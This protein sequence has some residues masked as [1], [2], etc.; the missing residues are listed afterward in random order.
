MPALIKDGPVWTLDLGGDENRFSPDF[1]TEVDTALDEI[2]ASAEPAVLLTTGSG[3]FFSNGLD[4]DWIMAHAGELPGYVDRIHAM[5]AKVLTL[6]V[7][8]VAAIN[9][10]AFG[11]GAMLAI[12]HDFRVMRDDRGFFCF[13]EVDILIPFTAGMNALIVAKT[14]PQAQVASMTTGRRW[15][16][17][18][19]AEAGLVDEATSLDRLREAAEAR[20][21]PLAGKDRRTLGRIKQVLYAGAVE[22]LLEPQPSDLTF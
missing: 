20:V 11:G 10:H 12:A 14:T 21:A 13:P 7:P 19:A 22:A 17:A 3:K 18:E 4:L 2:A 15:G 8:T 6:P 16:G 1:L 5:F 9:G